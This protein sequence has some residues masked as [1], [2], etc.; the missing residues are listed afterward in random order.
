MQLTLKMEKLGCVYIGVCA[1]SENA[2]DCYNSLDI[3]H[4]DTKHK[5][6][7]HNYTQYCY[8]D[9]YDTIMLIV[10]I[11]SFMLSAVNAEC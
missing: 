4:I 11:K 6:I 7:Q 10:A 3:Q 5:I 1:V 2:S 8:A 9:S